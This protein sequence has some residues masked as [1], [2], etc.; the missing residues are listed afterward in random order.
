MF[1]NISMKKKHIWLIEIVVWFII[2]TVGLVVFFYNAVAKDNIKNTF[3][4]FVDDA[5]GLVQGSPVRLMGIN[6]GHIRD[7]KIIDNKVFVAFVVTKDD[8]VLP[9]RMDAT[10]QFYGLAGSTSLELA[11]QNSKGAENITIKPMKTYRV[12]DYYDGS[13]LASNVMI[14]TYGSV[15]MSIDNANLVN[16][17]EILKQSGLLHSLSEDASKINSSQSVIIYKLTESTLKYSIEKAKQQHEVNMLNESNVEEDG[18]EN[19]E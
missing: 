7:V 14:D 16:N 13:T 11:P 3:Y 12:Q 10:I 1:Y 4:I 17:K 5:G 19:N 9:K 6:I 2:I 15:K 18:V 8:F